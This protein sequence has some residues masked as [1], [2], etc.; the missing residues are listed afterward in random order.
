MTARRVRKADA[1]RAAEARAAAA[2]RLAPPAVPAPAQLRLLGVLP[3]AAAAEAARGPGRP[4]G[5]S[6]KSAAAWRDY[7]T[8]RYGHPAEGLARLASVD[9]LQLASILQCTRLEAA[10]LVQRALAELL[11]YVQ[12]KLAA[13]Q[14]QLDGDRASPVTIVLPAAPA[15]SGGG[16]QVAAAPAGLPMMQFGKAR[17]IRDLT[18]APAAELDGAELDS[19]AQAVDRDGEG[20]A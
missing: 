19:A 10:Q 4:A 9:V 16:G 3:E 13:V 1:V 12:P 18:L 7:L 8:R 2:A 20:N 17:D 5:A 6:N 14:V 15:A 11:P